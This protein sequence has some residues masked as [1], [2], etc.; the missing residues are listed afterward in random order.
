M[1]PW[2]TGLLSTETVAALVVLIL[3]LLVHLVTKVHLESKQNTGEHAELRAASSRQAEEIASVRHELAGAREEIAGQAK[4]L[5]GVRQEMDRQRESTDRRFDSIDRRFDSTDR[6]LDQI[7][8]YLLT[9]R[10][11]KDD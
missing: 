2:F 10:S 9:N 4:E 8:N 7:L 3:V 11:D 1:G 5:A 6:K